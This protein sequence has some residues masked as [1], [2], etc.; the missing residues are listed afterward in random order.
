RPVLAVCCVIASMMITYMYGPVLATV[1]ELTPPHL[2]ATMVAFLLIGLNILGASLG[3]VI[4]AWLA[5]LLHSYTWG[6]F[7]TAQ[8]SLV[9]IPVFLL[10][11]R[12]Y[13]T[14]TVRLDVTLE[15]NTP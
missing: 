15:G 14:P 7:I 3:S 2:R 5:G 8:G 4:A 1:Q 10:A 13:R 12:Y 9:A 6:I 11:L